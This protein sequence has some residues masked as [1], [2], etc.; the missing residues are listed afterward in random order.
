MEGMFADA[1]NFTGTGLEKWN[2][3]S[4]ETISSMFKGTPKF[5]ADLGNWDIANTTTMTGIFCDSDLNPFLYPSWVNSEVAICEVEATN[6]T[7]T[8]NTTS[9]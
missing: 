8:T 9:A 1:V 4:V 7:N 2:V 6:S 3:G 5:G